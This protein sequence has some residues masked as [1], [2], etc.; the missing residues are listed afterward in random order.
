MKKTLEEKQ[1]EE[2]SGLFWTHP[3]NASTTDKWN[4]LKSF[5]Q[6]CQK[7]I[8]EDERKKLKGFIAK[9]KEDWALGLT[10]MADKSLD[11]QFK[12]A[13]AHLDVI[14]SDINKIL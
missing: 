3:L 9:K 13:E 7:D 5:L 1:I 8:R 6:K 12:T 10:Y 2:A 14:L 4:L 11:N